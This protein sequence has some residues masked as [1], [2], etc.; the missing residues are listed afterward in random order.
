MYSSSA[1]S[2]AGWAAGPGDKGNYNLN[3]I[4]QASVQAK[5]FT[6]EIS[7]AMIERRQ[8]SWGRV[9]VVNVEANSA[10]DINTNQTLRGA[11]G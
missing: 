3:Y 5:A 10:S 6:F 2:A 4:V 7:F 1:F 8:N 11:R 9:A